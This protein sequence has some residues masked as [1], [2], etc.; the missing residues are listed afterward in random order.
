MI[1]LSNTLEQTVQPGASVTFDV[2][3]EHT[4]CNECHRN[5]TGSVKLRDGG[6]YEVSFSANIGG[7][8]AAT[9]VQLALSLGEGAV[10]PDTTMISVPAA[11]ADR[12]NVSTIRGIPVCCCDYNRISVVNTGTVPVV[13]G[14]NPLLFVHRIG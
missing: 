14:A 3:R 2:V 12:N 7:E 11:V 5:G 13:V 1:V 9:P 10:I 4:G 6:V 8:T